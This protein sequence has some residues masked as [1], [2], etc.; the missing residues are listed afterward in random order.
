MVHLA[1]Y[2]PY[3]KT[4]GTIF[5]FRR[6]FYQLSTPSLEPFSGGHVTDRVT[7][8]AVAGAA[9]DAAISDGIGRPR[10]HWLDNHPSGTRE[11]ARIRPGVPIA[12]H[13]RLRLIRMG[14]EQGL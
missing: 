11:V 5:S 13:H 10:C 1:V 14:V 9:A 4:A 2:F 7:P 6:L 3:K 8:L 12:R